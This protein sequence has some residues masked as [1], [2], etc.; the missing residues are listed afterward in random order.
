MK[1][2]LNFDAESVIFEKTPKSQKVRKSFIMKKY[3]PLFA[4]AIP[5]GIVLWGVVTGVYYLGMANMTF[6]KGNGYLLGNLISF[7]SSS[8][9]IL[10]TRILNIEIGFFNYYYLLFIA[11]QTLIYYIISRW[12]YFKYILGSGAQ[13]NRITGNGQ[14]HR[15]EK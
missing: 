1:I 8:P 4:E 5:A 15:K 10:I 14:E 11:I 6:A 9:T 13:E 7:I 3:Q 12:V 2:F